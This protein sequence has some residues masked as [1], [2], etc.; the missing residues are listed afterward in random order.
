MLKVLCQDD[1][2][3]RPKNGTEIPTYLINCEFP[4]EKITVFPLADL[5][6]SFFLALAWSPQLPAK[7]TKWGR[8]YLAIGTKSGA[9]RI[10]EVL[11]G[12]DIILKATIQVNDKWITDLKWS[13]VHKSTIGE[14]MYTTLLM[15]KSHLVLTS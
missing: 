7:A 6:F 5:F 11:N 15:A 9:V 2:L 1:H 14:R 8:A 12:S 3:G 4:I 13:Q 10:M